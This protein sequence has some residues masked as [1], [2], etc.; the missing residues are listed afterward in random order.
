[1]VAKWIPVERC[2][3]PLCSTPKTLEPSRK[4]K[5]HHKKTQILP[6][7]PQTWHFSKVLHC[8]IFKLKLL[9]SQFRLIWTVIVTK[10]RKISENGEIYTTGKNFTLPLEVTAGTNLT[11]VP[12]SF[13]TTAA[14]AQWH[15]F[16]LAGKADQ[17]KTQ[18]QD[19]AANMWIYALLTLYS[20]TRVGIS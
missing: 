13:S 10:T 8:R 20:A 15:Y 7:S 6:P 18:F 19:L 11:S 4:N 1:M 14:A 9:R 12:S 17:H 16:I 2:L 5:K 3:L